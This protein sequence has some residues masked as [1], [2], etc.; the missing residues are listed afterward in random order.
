[1]S[2]SW[3]PN[4]S[5]AALPKRYNNKPAALGNVRGQ[6]AKAAATHT[7]VQQATASMGGLSLGSA[8]AAP[9]PAPAKPSAMNSLTSA[10]GSWNPFKSKGGR[11]KR[12]TRRRRS[13]RRR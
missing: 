6:A 9:A 2:V 7:A 5:A 8:A 4:S 1:M 12:K 13:H 3:G 10:L 11:T